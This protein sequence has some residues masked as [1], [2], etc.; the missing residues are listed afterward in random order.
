LDLSDQDFTIPREPDPLPPPR[1]EP[2]RLPLT[3]RQDEDHRGAL[4][5]DADLFQLFLDAV[6]RLPS[7]LTRAAPDENSPDEW[8]AFEIRI[9][10]LVFNSHEEG[11]VAAMSVV[12]DVPFTK[13]DSVEVGWLGAL[14]PG[15]A[16]VPTDARDGRAW[17]HL[18]LEVV[19]RLSG[20]TQHA[21]VDFALGAGLTAD[22]FKELDGTYM[23]ATQV[24][25]APMISGDLNI[26][27]DGAIGLLFHGGQSFPLGVRGSAIGVTD[28]SATLRVDLTVRLSLHVGY[29]YMIVR[30]KE[31]EVVAALGSRVLED[32]FA[33]PLVGFDFRF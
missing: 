4:W 5:S 32:S 29:R 2:A 6:R 13:D 18:T 9:D 14:L 3:L 11:R 17:H 8:P 12:V 15:V 33:G 23:S 24:H 16:N 22:S 10:G 27:H 7:E 26:W 25:V 1:E 21:T 31:D 28:L 20:Y 30:L 19:H